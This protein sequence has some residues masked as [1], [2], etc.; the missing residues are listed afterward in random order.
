MSICWKDSS[1]P[2]DNLALWLIMVILQIFC[3]SV[4]EAFLNSLSTFIALVP[5]VH[6]SLVEKLCSLWDLAPAVLVEIRP[7]PLQGGLGKCV[8]C[9]SRDIAVR[10]IWLPSSVPMEAKS[11]AEFP[12]TGPPKPGTRVRAS[13]GSPTRSDLTATVSVQQQSLLPGLVAVLLC[14]WDRISS[15]KTAFVFLLDQEEGGHRVPTSDSV[16]FATK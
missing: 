16:R 12:S 2:E 15:F 1:G 9:V 5:Y 13:S 3:L 7:G 4:T 11:T 10:S 14:C 8:R 6:P